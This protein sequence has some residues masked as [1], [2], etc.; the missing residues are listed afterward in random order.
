MPVAVQMP[1]PSYSGEKAQS[2][3]LWR[4]G[5]LVSACPVTWNSSA[6]RFQTRKNA[7]IQ[8]RLTSQLGGADQIAL[9]SV[10]LRMVRPP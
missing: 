2:K 9:G 5:N 10:R 4:K 6:M 8:T 3:M 1:A 7:T